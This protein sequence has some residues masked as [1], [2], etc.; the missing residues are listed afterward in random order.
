MSARS[1]VRSQQ[2]RDR[3]MMAEVEFVTV[4]QNMR[5]LFGAVRQSKS[6]RPFERPV[7]NQGICLTRKKEMPRGGVL[8]VQVVVAPV[9]KM[10][11]LMSVQSGVSRLTV[12]WMR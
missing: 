10:F 11:S 1:E 3:K 2:E 9:A 5:S 7:G 6:W 4:I 12:F 8:A